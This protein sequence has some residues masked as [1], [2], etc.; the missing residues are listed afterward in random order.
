L[1]GIDVNPVVLVVAFLMTLNVY[2]HT[3]M[4]REI[5]KQGGEQMQ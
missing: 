2:Q 4:E 1:A 3:Q 5:D